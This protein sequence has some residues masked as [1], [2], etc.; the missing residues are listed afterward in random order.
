MAEIDLSDLWLDDDDRYVEEL[1]LKAREV[2]TEEVYAEVCKKF[3]EV[4]WTI[5]DAAREIVEEV[6]RNAVLEAR[7]VSRIVRQNTS[8]G[9]YEGRF[10]VSS[11]LISWYRY[12]HHIG[13]GERSEKATTKIQEA[14]EHLL[15]YG[16]RNPKKPFLVPARI[17][18]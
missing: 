17:G 7:E 18:K 1:K 3:R 11:L 2:V 4:S 15:E 10:V 16:K 8:N 6:G 9:R 5:S 12:V 13:H 14:E